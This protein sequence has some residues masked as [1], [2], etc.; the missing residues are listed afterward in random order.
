MYIDQRI[1]RL[2]FRATKT[3]AGTRCRYYQAVTY[4]HT[5]S[6]LLCVAQVPGVRHA[7]VSDGFFLHDFLHL[8][9]SECN[10]SRMSQWTTTPGCSHWTS[11]TAS[12]SHSMT[13]WA[14]I[15]A[16]VASPALQ[17]AAAVASELSTQLPSFGRLQRKAIVACV[18]RCGLSRASRGASLKLRSASVLV[19]PTSL[20]KPLLGNAEQNKTRACVIATN[21]C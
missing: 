20:R 17:Q 16:P 5:P 12:L 19:S 11:F 2:R 10:I 8:M 15:L 18:K 13:T 3:R 4:R 14:R 7:A 9:T 6:A 1:R 21:E